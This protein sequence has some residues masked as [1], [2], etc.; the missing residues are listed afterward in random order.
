MAVAG[1]KFEKGLNGIKGFPKIDG[2]DFNAVFASGVSAPA[3]SVTRLNSSGELALGV[4]TAFA[5]PL[6][7]FHNSDDLSVSHTLGGNPATDKKAWITTD[8]VGRVLCIPAIAA[9]ELTTTVFKTDDSYVPNAALK[10]DTTGDYA[11]M[12][13]TGTHGTDTIVGVVSRG[14]IDNVYG[15]DCV[16]FWPVFLPPQ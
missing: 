7:T 2:V 16:A 14:V 13:R 5:M 8:P 15:Y 1:E 4:G 3:G 11:G 9:V 12:I 10:S 6:F